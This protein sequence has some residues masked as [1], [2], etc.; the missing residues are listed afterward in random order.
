MDNAKISFADNQ[1]FSKMLAA[2]MAA[3]RAAV[4]ELRNVFQYDILVSNSIALYLKL[5][6]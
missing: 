6:T 2:E 3:G 5:I 4:I 1:G